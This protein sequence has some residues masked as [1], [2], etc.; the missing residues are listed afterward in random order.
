[1]IP[2]RRALAFLA[3]A[4]VAL[5]APA[6]ASRPPQVRVLPPRP[7]PGPEAAAPAAGAGR[8]SPD[9]YAAGS[10]IARTAE[11]LLGS[12][13]REGGAMPD[14]FDCS[15]LVNY[16]FARHGIAV[17]R[18]VRRQASAGS[19][20]DRGG[21]MPGDLVFF[22]AGGSGPTH[23]AS[24]SAAAGSSTRRKAAMSCGSNRWQR[25]TGLRASLPPGV[26]LAPSE[27]GVIGGAACSR[28]QGRRAGRSGNSRNTRSASVNCRRC[29][30]CGRGT[31][32]TARGARGCSARRSR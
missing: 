14:G 19:P 29:L 18:D 16:V 32:W 7:A 9:E 4:A 2:R 31:I 10:A 28:L 11:A 15:G 25:P 24:P 13:Y 1:M 30:R 21:I 27:P 8:A 12:P 6:C 20:V 17:P 26:S 23:V 3:L 22:A 5:W